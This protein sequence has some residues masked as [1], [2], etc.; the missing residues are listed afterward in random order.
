M[1]FPTE[2]EFQLAFFFKLYSVIICMDSDEELGKYYLDE[3]LGKISFQ[4]LKFPGKKSGHKTMA[5]INKNNNSTSDS[6][7]KFV[8]EGLKL[9]D[10]IHV[11]ETMNYHHSPSFEKPDIFTKEDIEK[12]DASMACQTKLHKILIK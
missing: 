7:R 10:S 12:W 4:F 3:K 5:I 1:V 2:G 6:V 8:E 11:L 9:K